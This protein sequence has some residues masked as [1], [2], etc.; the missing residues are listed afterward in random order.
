LESSA[1][2]H[3]SRWCQAFCVN[4]VSV[5]LKFSCVPAGAVRREY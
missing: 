5:D 1:P 3:S 2:L 4:G